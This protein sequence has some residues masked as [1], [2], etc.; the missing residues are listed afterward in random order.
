MC[1]E[2]S[3]SEKLIQIILIA[4]P[5][6]RKKL[7]VARLEQLRQRIAIHYH[8]EPLNPKE[9]QEY[10]L[11]RLA[12]AATNGRDVK[13]LFQPACFDLVYRYSRGLP[14]LINKVCDYALFTGC[15]SESSIISMEMIKEAIAEL[16]HGEEKENEQIYQSA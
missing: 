5:E 13:A 16:H 15:V 10:I 1:I 4:Q 2:N 12:Q 9:T 7:E 8:L 3:H 11:H 6:L 14:R